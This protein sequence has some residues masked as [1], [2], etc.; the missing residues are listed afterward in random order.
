MVIILVSRS[1]N[2][3]Q[4]G[5]KSYLDLD[6]NIRC[7]DP[8]YHKPFIFY[9]SL[10]L[11][12]LWVIIIPL[13][14]FIKIKQG[15]LKK[16]SIFIEIKY[17]FI[18]AGYKEKLYYW[19]FGKL[20]YKSLLIIISILM[21]QNEVLKICLM[22]VALLFKIFVIFKFKPYISKNFNSI[23]Q[24]SAIICALSLNLTSVIQNVSNPYQQAILCIFLISLNLKYILQLAFGI[25]SRTISSD[26]LKRNKIENCL[27]YFKQKY[28][29]LFEN[30]QI[31]NKNKIKSLIKLKIVK[32]K[33][34]MLVE[35]FKNHN[36]YGIE[37]VQQHFNLRTQIASS[38]ST[39][40]IVTNRFILNSKQESPTLYRKQNS[41]KNMRDKWDYYT[42]RTKDSP[43]N[44]NR[45]INE[46][47]TQDYIKETSIMEIG[48][49][50]T[51]S[52]DQ[53]KQLIS[54]IELN[55]KYQEMLTLDS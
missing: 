9:F 55:K 48:N 34:K 50:Q 45:F 17:S 21:Q 46:D 37:S 14:L 15:K 44:T 7:F 1:L 28:P 43:L 13:F 3:I 35:Y 23:L 51:N 11:L 30:I 29:S 20:V 42:R 36:F 2:C 32:S 5:D 10:P 54:N 8:K 4:I 16:W 41:F 38:K 52:D 47:K 26:Q 33:V 12:V 25:S 49:L 6:I 27:I 39:Q 40:K 22:N 53:G 24:K 31:E 19:E 18:F